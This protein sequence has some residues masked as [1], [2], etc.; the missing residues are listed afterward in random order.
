MTG[1][2]AFTALETL[3][4]TNNSFSTIDLSA[5]TLLKVLNLSINSSLITLDVTALNSLEVLRSFDTSISAIDLSNNTALKE[6]Q[7][8]RTNLSALDLSNNPNLED[9]RL[10]SATLLRT[11][12]LKNGN[13]TKITNFETVNTSI[14]CINVDNE[15][16]GINNLGYHNSS[17]FSEH[18]FETNVPDDNFEN[19]LETHDA[20]GNVV[21]IGDASSMGNG[22]ANDDYV[23][24]AN[25]SSVT[26]LNIANL[27][28]SDLT[29]IEAFTV[30]EI[31]NITGNTAISNLD[32]SLNSSL[33]SFTAQNTSLESLDIRNG[34]NTS[35]T[36][37][38]TTGSTNLDCVNVDD[39]NYSTANWTSI[40]PETTFAPD[41]SYIYMPDDN[42]EMYLETHTPTGTVVTIGDANS[43]GNGV[44]DNYVVPDR[45]EVAT[46][47]NINNQSIS[48]L[49]GIEGFT[50]LIELRMD[51]NNITSLDLSDFSGLNVL[52]C[53]NNP[54][55][56][57]NI[58]TLVGSLQ[59]LDISGT[60]LTSIDLS[61]FTLL[62]SFSAN[63]TSFTTL[64]VSNNTSLETLK[65]GNSYRVNN[66]YKR[67]HSI[68]HFGYRRDLNSFFIT[69]IT[70]KFDKFKCK[71]CSINHIR[72]Q[73]RKQ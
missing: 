50:S 62:T 47:L 71:K 39:A 30:L 35:I 53:T 26:S 61:L 29:G 67:E 51:S 70:Y 42:F 38:N 22:V 49:T 41:C 66:R 59:T 27:N 5:N 34:Q 9:I 54:I 36:T 43:M 13:N 12:D 16:F 48:D 52:S 7:I 4:A 73:E 19:Y 18:C 20:S 28:I 58:S 65:L 8:G 56:S 3:V 11:L 68:N 69:C 1:I 6:I 31:L 60:N 23:L 33:T 55:N 32:L 63:N 10:T 44:M 64:D 72:C 25:I 14:G 2:G 57:L 46:T 40:E 37:F 21:S 17:A 15:Q 24:T 45:V